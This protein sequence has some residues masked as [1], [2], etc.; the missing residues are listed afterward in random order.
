MNKLEI[1]EI[2]VLSA[3]AVQPGL[4]KVI[5]A[6][7]KVSSHPVKITFATA[8]II[9]SRIGAADGLDAVIA[10]PAVL[11]EWIKAGKASVADCVTVGRI[12][13]GV[14]VRDGT[15]Q[16]K[17]ATVDEFKQSLISAESLVYNQASTGIYLEKLFE[18]LAIAEQLKTKTVR[19]PDAAAVLDHISKGKGCEIG[20]GATTVIIDGQNKGLKF[21]GA[22]PAEI[23]NYTAYAATVVTAPTASDAAREFIRFLKEP[24]AKDAL[25]AAG[26]Q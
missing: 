21:V 9:L 3:G 4:V 24:V 15:S 8:P 16:P 18:R 10:P 22:L 2:N 13:V 5:D 14:V 17:I 12:G 25:A 26:I 7:R 19:Y 1:R 6:F 11:E 23:Q 20:L